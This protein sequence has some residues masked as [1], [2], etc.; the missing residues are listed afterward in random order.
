M[1]KEN[2]LTLKIGDVV[3]AYGITYEVVSTDDERRTLRSSQIPH[4]E[5]TLIPEH[6]LVPSLLLWRRVEDI[7]FETSFP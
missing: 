2:F 3:W 5:I 6:F 7:P 1:T 4:E